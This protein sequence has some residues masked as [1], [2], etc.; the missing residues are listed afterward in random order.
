MAKR[1]MGAVMALLIWIPTVFAQPDLSGVREQAAYIVGGFLK[2]REALKAENA[3][4]RTEASAQANVARTHSG[5]VMVERRLLGEFPS[6]TVAPKGKTWDIMHENGFTGDFDIACVLLK[7]DAYLCN[8]WKH[9]HAEG[10]GVA[11]DMPKDGIVLDGLTY[12]R[13]GVHYA[14]EAV[15]V[16]LVKFPTL[17]AMVY[18]LKAKDG[19]S[20]HIIRHLGCNNV[21]RVNGWQKSLSTRVTEATLP[22]PLTQQACATKWLQVNIWD[23]SALEVSGVR[24]TIVETRR[25][26]KESVFVP[27]RLSRKYGAT[28]RSM[29]SGG[30]LGY[31]GQV[32]HVQIILRKVDGK[33]YQIFQGEVK[34]RYRMMFPDNFTQEGD[35]MRIVFSDY[36]VLASPTP[37]DIHVMQSEVKIGCGETFHVHAIDNPN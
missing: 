33:E 18:E 19:T 13:K 26:A 36:G 7:L 5:N 4:L 8:E 34:G 29:Q 3:R 12:T 2:E 32:H 15:K 25:A 28:L 23:P 16:G 11:M 22:L 37:T 21:S 1:L 17:A 24:E 27:N 20:V 30:R 14:Q 10:K 35:T 31:G 6:S 9:A